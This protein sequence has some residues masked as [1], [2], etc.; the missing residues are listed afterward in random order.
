MKGL[1]P[2]ELE[3]LQLT[4]N[5]MT[6]FETALQLFRSPKTIR[7]H[8]SKIIAKLGVNNMTEACAVGMYYELVTY[9]GKGGEHLYGPKSR[10]I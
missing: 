2:T 6:A 8:R 4:T 3:I 1:T 5:G 9:E 10:G 7:V